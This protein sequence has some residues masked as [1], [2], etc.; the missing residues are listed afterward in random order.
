MSTKKIAKSASAPTANQK[1]STP[2]FFENF[3]NKGVFICSTLI[4]I[5]AFFVFKDFMLQKKMFLYKD[6]G[7]DTLN[8]VLPYF[9][10]M[11]DYIAA[12][13]LPKWSWAEGLGQ[14]IFAG[15]IRDPF[16]LIS[17][18]AGSKALPEI[19]I[20]I[21]VLKIILAGSIFYLFLKTLK[22]SNFSATLAALMFSFS[23]FMIIG[24]CWYLFTYE[25]L[26]V[27]LIL[28]AFEIFYQKNKWFLF[29][30][31]VFLICISMPFNLYVYG[32]F[33]AVYVAFRLIQQPHFSIKVLFTLYGKLVFLGIIGIL[34]SGPF[35]LE[36]LI[37]LIESPRGSGGSSYFQ[38]LSSKPIFGLSDKWQFGSAMMRMFSSDILGS[39]SDFMGWNQ[40]FLEAPM[41]YCGLLS[42]LL[43]PQVF[44]FLSKPVRR[45]YVV[46]LVFWFLPTLFPYFRYAFWLFSGDYY[47]AYSFF[48]SLV[49]LI[50]SAM[51]M[52][53]ILKN[54]KVN[55]ITLAITSVVLLILVSYPYFK[56]IDFLRGRTYDT[57]VDE[58]VSLFVKVFLV[59]YSV[60]IFAFGKT[61]DISKLKYILLLLVGIE[62]IYLSGLTV[63]RRKIV[64]SS[65]L[66][67]K[68]GYNDYTLEAVGYLKQLDKSFYRID[69]GG[70]FSGGAIHGSLIDH[71]IQGYYGT[72]TYNSFA[73]PNYINYFRAYG[74]S[75][76]EN[77]FEARW[78]PGLIGKP[79]LETL[80]HVKYI[81][82]KTGF[83]QNWAASHDSINKFGDVVVL[84]S[85]YQL[86]FGYTYSNFIKQS[87]F[88]QLSFIQKDF[89]S[90]IACAVKD[91]SVPT[92]SGLRQFTLKD[93]INPSQF[94]YEIYKNY[95]NDLKK[96][97]LTL[98]HFGQTEIVGTINVDE[99]KIC[100]LSMTFDD[101]WKLKI[102][103][104]ET[105]KLYLNNGLTGIYLTKGRHQIDMQYNLRYFSKGLILSLLG[106]VLTLSIWLFQRRKIKTVP[107]I[108]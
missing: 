86:P 101:G 105:D 84:K 78:V 6:I 11:A 67:E 28:Y 58:T 62:L 47:R 1:I 23:G 38:T 103:G 15:F 40:N 80:N 21:E 5:V 74:I 56:N 64:T 17:Y 16:Q 76:K 59:T 39:G 93:T 79:I 61:K 106:L 69:K 75:K 95:V 4:L 96:D 88:D 27:A 73:H 77:E 26:S 25:A 51:A 2:D 50:Y 68:V 99:N 100:N 107:T 32:I 55:I 91:E 54:R 14:C 108:N 71:K 87:D 41:S 24:A 42:L 49:F 19:F 8:G 34:L 85:R 29:V 22:V 81:L 20:Y 37:Q 53:Q 35:L 70:Y 46:L 94:T 36:N 10:G 97:T 66:K 3:G 48:V 9:A 30:L 92:V 72:S 57:I 43:M 12:Y 90:L 7:S 83:A 102:D 18:A 31:S 63:N 98:K 89:V 104:K 44:S 13:G 33:L 60:L 82:T 52:D 45:W 65:E